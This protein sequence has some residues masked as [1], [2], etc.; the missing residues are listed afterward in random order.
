MMDVQALLAV[1][2]LIREISSGIRAL[3]AVADQ[4]EHAAKTGKPLTLDQLKSYQLADDQARDVLARAIEE[5]ELR[6]EFH[7]PEGAD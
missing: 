6:K 4:A 1:V 5:A 2:A 3:D 7:A